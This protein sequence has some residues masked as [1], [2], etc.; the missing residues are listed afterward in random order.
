ML[1]IVDLKAPLFQRCI[2]LLKNYNAFMKRPIIFLDKIE[3]KTLEARDLLKEES[4][5]EFLNLDLSNPSAFFS[6]QLCP[7]V[8]VCMDLRASVKFLRQHKDVLRDTSSKFCL[9]TAKALDKKEE[10]LFYTLGG[11]EIIL[12]E[13]IPTKTIAHK[14]KLYAKALPDFDEE[15][16]NTLKLKHLTI[17]K[18]SKQPPEKRSEINYETIDFFVLEKFCGK[19]LRS[20]TD[21]EMALEKYES[22]P[23]A[24]NQQV[25][26]NLFEEMR[27]DAYSNNFQVISEFLEIPKH[28][29]KRTGEIADDTFRSVLIGVLFNLAD[30]MRTEITSIKNKKN[31]KQILENPHKGIFNR[32]YWLDEKFKSILND[33]T[34]GGELE[35]LGIRK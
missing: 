11:T 10:N 29:L 4:E 15:T 17:E 32:L 22:A 16:R 19:S 34:I 8:L 33:D 9:M 18:M 20:I 2:L 12:D 30:F 28:I 7:C 24:A 25:I 23:D 35:K 6:A 1:S 26:Y 14:F 13:K 3:G 31:R 5:L 27:R 21:L